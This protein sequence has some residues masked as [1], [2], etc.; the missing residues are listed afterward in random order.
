MYN[1]SISNEENPTWLRQNLL[2]VITTYNKFMKARN[3]TT[4]SNAY[5][6][7]N[8]RAEIQRALESL[9]P[10]NFESAN[11]TPIEEASIAGTTSSFFNTLGSKASGLANNF[12]NSWNNFAR[13]VPGFNTPKQGG[14]TKK[15]KKNKNKK[16]RKSKY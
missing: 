4:S 15:G 13:T 2:A 3:L 7:E 12:G 9:L 6:P 11:G 5:G 16:S 8:R 10:E 1:A 14:K